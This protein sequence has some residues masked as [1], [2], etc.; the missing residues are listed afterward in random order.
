MKINYSFIALV[1][2][3]LY[4]GY[5]NYLLL[6]CL[7]LLIHEL[8]HILFIKMFKVKVIKFSLSLYGGTLQLDNKQFNKINQ[9]KKILIYIG[10]L[11]INLI[12]YIVFKNTMFSKMNLLLFCFNILPIYPLDGYN[13]LTTLIKNETKMHNLIILCL[14]IMLI[15]SIYSSSLGLGIITFLLLYKNIIYYFNKDKIYLLNL[16]SNM[17]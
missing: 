3:S 10:G 9:T 14:V 15:I 1:I 2:F 17:I 7:C 13:V 4:T 12:F 16:V 6:F 5:I 8:G 11:I